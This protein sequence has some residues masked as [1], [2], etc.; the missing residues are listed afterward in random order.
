MT[1]I[2]I[3][4]FFA[5]RIHIRVIFIFLNKFQDLIREWHYYSSYLFLF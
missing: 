2:K 1:Q 5:Y 3:I 4:I